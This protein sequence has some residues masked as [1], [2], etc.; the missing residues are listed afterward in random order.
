MVS[1][2]ALARAPGSVAVAAFRIGSARADGPSE[3][4]H[5]AEQPAQHQQV[6]NVA[7]GGQWRTRSGLN[8]LDAAFQI[9][10]RHHPGAVNQ[11]HGPA[12]GAACRQLLHLLAHRFS[13]IFTVGWL[14][15]VIGVVLVEQRADFGHLAALGLAL[16]SRA[17]QAPDE[18]DRQGDHQRPQDNPAFLTQ[19]GKCSEIVHHP[20]IE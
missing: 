12:N 6:G 7:H 14:F 2:S 18:E 15:G 13:E 9:R 19:L 17:Q 8:R 20:K 5:R 4:Q 16:L 3:A 10:R 11:L 1:A